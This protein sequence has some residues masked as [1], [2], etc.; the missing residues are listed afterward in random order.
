MRIITTF[1]IALLLV[2]SYG[3]YQLKYSVETL[4]QRAVALDRQIVA[5]EDSI[6]VLQAEWALLTRPQ[7]LQKLSGRF[8]ELTPLQPEQIVL[9]PDLIARSPAVLPFD[10]P[11]LKAD[12]NRKELLNSRRRDVANV[13]FPA[14]EMRGVTGQ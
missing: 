10:N 2:V 3:L 4:R 5:D 7:R 14:L 8:L 12:Y 11:V 13:Q 1:A 6:D 9:L